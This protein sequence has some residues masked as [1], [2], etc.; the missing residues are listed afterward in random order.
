M[1][2]PL[3]CEISD[4]INNSQNHNTRLFRPEW[5]GSV[6]GRAGQNCDRIL[7]LISSALEDESINITL[8]NHTK[9]ISLNID[10]Y[11]YVKRSEID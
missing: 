1:A 9:L 5:H 10:R 4:Q 8:S 3:L 7:V 11:I 2:C 6:G